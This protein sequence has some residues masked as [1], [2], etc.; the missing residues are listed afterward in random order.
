VTCKIDTD[1]KVGVIVEI[2]SETD[3]A[4]K[5]DG[6]RNF[7]SMVAQTIID[8]DVADVDA[9]KEVNG[10]GTDEKI[11]DILTE[12]IATIGENIQIR[13]FARLSGDGLFLYVHNDGGTGFGTH[14]TIVKISADDF[15]DEVADCVKGVLLHI[16]AMAP[17]F[18]D[19]DAIPQSV[20]DE[21]R[22]TQY[23]RI[24]EENADKPKPQ[25][26]VEK[27]LEGRMNKFYEESCLLTQEFV[28]APDSTVAEYL[29]AVKK[30]VSIEQFVRFEKGEGIAKKEENFADEV[31]GMIG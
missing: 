27:I 22:D 13:R 7:V 18:I 8:N 29:A 9:L 3:F 5:G 20:R 26:V 25:N 1:K 4:A 17:E 11:A 14:G 24:M 12:K 2:N 16:T 30:N 10:S 28:K 23:N 15:G 19:T 21:E 6:F 31:A